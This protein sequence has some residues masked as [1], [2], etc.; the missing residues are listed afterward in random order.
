MW[1]DST[2][3]APTLWDLAAIVLEEVEAC[4]GDE[5]EGERLATEVMVHFIRS[6]VRNMVV[7]GPDREGSSGSEGRSPPVGRRSAPR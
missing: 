6:H 1:F 4:C 3:F 5:Q 2:S 7:T